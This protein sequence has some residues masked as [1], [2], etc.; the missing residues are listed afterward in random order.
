MS[1]QYVIEFGSSKTS[2]GRIQIGKSSAEHRLKVISVKSEGIQAGVISDFDLAQKTLQ[3]IISLAEDEY[4]W[5]IQSLSLGVS[6]KCIVGKESS[7]LFMVEN[8]SKVS[9]HTINDLRDEYLSNYA[10][11]SKELLHSFPIGYKIDDRD[12]ILNPLGF[13]GSVIEANF[14]IV[15]AQKSFLK[16]FVSVI[17]SCGIKVSKINSSLVCTCLHILSSLHSNGSFIFVD[18]GK[19]KT[20]IA[21]IVEGR[22]TNISVV[23]VGGKQITSDIG[24]FFSTSVEESERLK[25]S[26]MSDSNPVGDTESKIIPVIGERMKEIADLVLNSIGPRFSFPKMLFLS[27]GSAHLYSAVEIFSSR[28]GIE[29]AV[30]TPSGPS[31][32]QKNDEA[33]FS[34]CQSSIIG[35]A[36]SAIEL[37]NHRI[38]R[39]K[40]RRFSNFIRSVKG[41]IAE[42]I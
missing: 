34:P 23:Q 4:G 5:N 40:G 30:W 3:D 1:I 38:K 6:G 21:K 37:S 31:H 16:D 27:G 19:D 22:I 36:S 12:W 9:V 41:V 17:N 13:S 7:S 26:V 8:N 39:L 15:T 32:P 42:L 11:E 28:S 20:E 35:L 29:S 10:S 14:F 18:I 24:H 25:L 33:T 2:L